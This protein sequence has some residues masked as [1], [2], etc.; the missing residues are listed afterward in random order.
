MNRKELFEKLFTEYPGHVGY[1]PAAVTLA[2]CAAVCATLAIGGYTIG[3][4]VLATTF[5]IESSSS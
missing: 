1:A 5:G 2:I 4:E 3:K